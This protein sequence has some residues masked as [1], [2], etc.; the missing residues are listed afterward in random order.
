MSI[1]ERHTFLL[2]D[3]ARDFAAYFVELYAYGY[4]GSATVY[5]DGD[6]WIVSTTRFASCD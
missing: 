1:R 6:K 5:Q 3:A 4:C 2:E